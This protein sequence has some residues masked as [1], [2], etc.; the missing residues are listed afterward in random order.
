MNCSQILVYI[1]KKTRKTNSL[2]KKKRKLK[3]LEV[4]TRIV[5][6]DHSNLDPDLIIITK[7][8]NP[9]LHIDHHTETIPAIDTTQDQDVDHDRT[10]Q[11]TPSDDKI[12][13]IV[14]Y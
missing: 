3:I 9:E 10:H 4:D 11:E 6:L 1:L 13:L 14:N 7:Y 12:I 8:T 2:N 5:H